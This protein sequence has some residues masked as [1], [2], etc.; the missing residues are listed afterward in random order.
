MIYFRQLL[1]L[2]VITLLGF[3]LFV[4]LFWLGVGASITIL[5][6]RGIALALAVAVAIGLVSG[7]IGRRN[8]DASFPIAAAA[9]SLSFNICFLVLLPVTVDRS[10][11][12]YLLSTIEKREDAGVDSAALQRAFVDGYV[13][14]LGAVDR[15]LDEQTKSGNLTVGKDGKVRLTAQGQRFMQFSRLIA[16]LF[17]TDRRFINGSPADAPSARK[18]RHRN[19]SKHN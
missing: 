1:L 4:L 2:G 8:G 19:L 17:G 9:L 3:G 16:R 6:Y 7:W 11:T 18:Q 13:V 15:R 14:K 10:V 12:V 5:F